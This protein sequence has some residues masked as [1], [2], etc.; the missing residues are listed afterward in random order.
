MDY[1]EYRDGELFCE[2]VAAADVAGAAG[3]PVYVYSKSTLEEHCRRIAAAFE[4]LD[5]LICYSIK[6]SGNVHIC[7]VLAEAG[8]GM[9]VVSGGEIERAFLA[10]CLMSKVVYAGVGKADEEIRAALDGRFSPLVCWEGLP[11]GVDPAGRGPIGW[12]NIESEQEF[13][14]IARIA[15]E[16]SVS[17][18]AALRVNPDVDPQTHRYTTTG[19]KET[20]FGVD[21]E[22]ARQFFETYGHDEHL[23]LNAIHLHLG[24]PIY[25]TEPY[26]TAIG[27][28]LDLI[29]DLEKSGFK[30]TALDLGGGFGADYETDRSPAATE[31]AAA[32]VPLLRE[33]AEAGMKVILEPGRTISANAG[34][35][36][37][38]VQYVKESG[39]KKFVI[40]DA[41][42][43]TLIRPSLYEA[44][45]FAWP[46]SVKA[47]HVPARRA[48]ELDLPGLEAC[49]LVG[50][51]C[52]TGDFLALGRKM[53]RMGRGDLVAIF[54]AGAYGMV[55]ASNYNSHTLPA[56]VLVDGD[57]SVL[58]RKRQEVVDLLGPEMGREG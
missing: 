20:K 14:N 40:C 48:E 19:K 18:N 24:S 37:T 11:E 36:L 35:L 41:G 13:E 21:L 15:G 45:H 43:H 39:E 2:D 52:E 12:F 4:A 10:G 27:K 23:K 38:E 34:V 17:T 46:A 47:E 3:T 54:G 58:I 56:E 57:Q 28:A 29:D 5:P 1:F 22:R 8:A 31:Y 30:I 25:T 53:P 26:V 6:S 9:D 32:I 7:K 50:P 44:F 33:R 51:I 16:L 49:D 55:M 42:M